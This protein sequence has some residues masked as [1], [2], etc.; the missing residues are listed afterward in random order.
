M[1]ELPPHLGSRP[2]TSSQGPHRQLTDRATPELWGRLV[3][4]AMSIHQVREGQ[5]SVSMA[6]S[7]ALLLS[8]L[9]ADHG[10]WSLATSGPIEPAHIHGVTDTSIH[11]CLPV[12]RAVE[13]CSKG[14]GELHPY[15]DYATQVMLYAP[16]NEQELG[17]VLGLLRESVTFALTAGRL[18]LNAERS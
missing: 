15:A 18:N 13:L 2:A 9:F 8:E 12:K 5:S 16:R 1:V 17:T 6:D 3:F 7:R 14:W 10:E 4:E 11:L